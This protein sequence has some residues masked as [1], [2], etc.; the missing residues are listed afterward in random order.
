MCGD[1]KYYDSKSKDVAALAR[2]VSLHRKKGKLGGIKR[3]KAAT[4]FAC[5]PPKA[6]KANMNSKSIPNQC[7]STNDMMNK[8]EKWSRSN[9]NKCSDQRANQI[10]GR[11][12]VGE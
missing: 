4:Y 9:D 2:Y 1:T 6:R 11:R 12:D 5:R 7:N 8:K 10:K 3:R